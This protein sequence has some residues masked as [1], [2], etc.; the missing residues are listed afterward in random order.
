MGRIGRARA[1]N[2]ANRVFYKAIKEREIFLKANQDKECVLC[3]NNMALFEIHRIHDGKYCYDGET[4][5]LCS[6]CMSNQK[7][8][9]DLFFAVIPK[10]HREALE[11]IAK[12]TVEKKDDLRLDFSEA[13]WKINPKR[14]KKKEMK[15]IKKDIKDFKL[16]EPIVF[17]NPRFDVPKHLKASGG[18]KELPNR[19]TAFYEASYGINGEPN[20]HHSKPSETEPDYDGIL[21]IQ[22][23]IT[24]EHMLVEQH[25]KEIKELIEAFVK[26]IDK[27]LESGDT[28]GIKF[29]IELRDEYEGMIK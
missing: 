10:W 20:V 9:D 18:E 7:C 28:N 15:Y 6:M 8:F 22:A 24:H 14:M 4:V 2:K 5:L 23:M 26:R 1:T 12:H 3:G 13:I 11:T 19:E 21:T 29:L 27:W 25:K 17:T 16:D